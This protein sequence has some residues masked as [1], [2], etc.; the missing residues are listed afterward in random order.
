[1]YEQGIDEGLSQ[2]HLDTGISLGI[3]ESQSR[4]W[5]NVIGRSPAFWQYLYPRLQQAFPAQ[6]GKMAAEEFLRGINAVR[7]G[8]IR[9]EADEVTYNLHVL[10]RFE[11]ELALIRGEIAARDLP[12]V[13]NAKYQEYLGVTV[14]SNANGVLQDVHWPHGSFGYFP[15]YTI[16]NLAAAQFWAVYAKDDPQSD[17]TLREGN[18]IKIRQWL[19]DKIYR[20]GSVYLP[21]T[22]LKMVTGEG[23]NSDH[24]VRYL[25]KKYGEIA[26]A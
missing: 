17:Q 24:F 11:L 25:K 5:E 22:L 3:H 9:V 12:A 16:G 15:T 10:I 8:M 13:W 18:F 23:L 19:T 1:M 20:H 26:G 6:F 4:L 21:D 14:D 2:T 7:P